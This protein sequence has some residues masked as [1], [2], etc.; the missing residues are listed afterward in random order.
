[1]GA[2]ACLG[3]GAPCAGVDVWG[4]GNM[5]AHEKVEVM[6]DESEHS[7]RLA[8]CNLDWT[9]V[10]AKDI[11]L[12]A[13][14]FKPDMGSIKKVTIYPSDFGLK[15]MAEEDTNGPAAFLRSDTTVGQELGD[16]DMTD[17]DDVDM[18]KLRQYVYCPYAPAAHPLLA[19]GNVPLH[20]CHYGRLLCVCAPRESPPGPLL[21]LLS[22]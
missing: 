11:F 9:K 7:N 6:E 12:L 22:V 10:S 16:E 5:G 21:S 20:R 18:E 14:S 3:V 19:D 13:N 2:L 4:G 8:V 1:M 15:R 17:M